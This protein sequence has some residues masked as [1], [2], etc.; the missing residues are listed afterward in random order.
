MAAIPVDRHF[1]SEFGVIETA[2][3]GRIIAFHEK[4]AD[5]PTIPGDPDKV[6]ASMGNYVFST[7]TLLREL[8]ADAGRE[9]SAHDFGRDILPT[10]VNR[11]D[12]F[13]Y[14]FQ[15]NHIP[16]EAPDAAV[17]PFSNSSAW[18]MALLAWRSPSMRASSPTRPLRLP[19]I[20]SIATE[21][22]S[23][24]WSFVTTK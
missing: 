24:L 23:P 19:W 22:R 3:D 7:R 10:L 17:Y 13:A 12:M 9:Q 18:A 5:A 15:T 6:F 8:H 2:R 4:R 16:G 21:A 1:A 20:G 11:V 14:D